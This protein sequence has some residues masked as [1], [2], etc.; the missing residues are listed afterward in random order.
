MLAPCQLTV[1][2]VCLQLHK[3]LST[4]AAI[5]LEAKAALEEAQSAL[6]AVKADATQQLSKLRREID[7]RDERIRKL[8]NQLR[9]AYSGLTRAAMRASTAAAEKGTCSVRVSR[10]GVGGDVLKG[11]S[12]E[13]V[14]QGLGQHENIIELVVAEAVLL[15]SAAKHV[16]VCCQHCFSLHSM[17]MKNHVSLHQCP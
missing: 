9:G 8:E 7:T 17:D 6:Q 1:Y 12:I 15:V 2:V 16:D 5:T 10:I 13:D 3:L 4:E 14:M 11:A